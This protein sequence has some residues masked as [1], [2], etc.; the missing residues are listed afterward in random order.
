MLWHVYHYHAPYGQ[1]AIQKWIVKGRLDVS[2]NF[3][4]LIAKYM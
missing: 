3:I 4:G 2:I 1:T